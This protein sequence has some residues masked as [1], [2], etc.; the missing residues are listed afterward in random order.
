M[1]VLKGRIR[2][3]YKEL[4]EKL[5]AGKT[6]DHLYQRC[7]L[8]R[9]ELEEI[10][11]LKND[12]HIK[13]AE[14]LL[15]FLLTQTEDF[16]DCFL[17]SLT[18]TDQAYGRQ[19]IILEGLFY[20]TLLVLLHHTASSSNSSDDTHASFATDGRTAIPAPVKSN[21]IGLDCHINVLL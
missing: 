11:T 8:N 14:W 20:I 6:A 2:A 3:I 16:Y 1:C 5:D 19:W 21:W 17:N 7:A 13:A 10:Q 4:S 15:D 18:Q 12:Q 9:K